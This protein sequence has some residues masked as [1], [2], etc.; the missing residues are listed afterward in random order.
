MQKYR[1]SLV[2][3][4]MGGGYTTTGFSHYYQHYYY[5]EQFSQYNA[6]VKFY[7]FPIYYHYM[8]IYSTTNDKPVLGEIA[9]MGLCQILKRCILCITTK[10]PKNS[11]SCVS[12][13][14][15]SQATS[16]NPHFFGFPPPSV[17]FYAGS[18]VLFI[19]IVMFL[20]SGIKNI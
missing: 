19:F 18:G 6:I 15:P 16:T 20:P 11:S 2:G 7:E 5:I 10:T 9:K 14:Y 8:V 12:V 4:G 13:E 1:L 3:G 17:Y